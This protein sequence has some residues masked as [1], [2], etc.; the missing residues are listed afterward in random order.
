MTQ[1]LYYDIILVH[2]FLYEFVYYCMSK[3]QYQ[4]RF[5]EVAEVKLVWPK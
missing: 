5:I 1:I 4:V 3:K 2:F